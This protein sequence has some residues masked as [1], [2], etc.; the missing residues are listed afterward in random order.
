[1]HCLDCGWTQGDVSAEAG[2]QPVLCI[3]PAC[4]VAN[5][6][7]ERYCQRCNTLLPTAAGTMLQGRF[8]IESLLAEGGFGR[9]YR[10][11][12]IQTNQPVA[13]KDMISPDPAEFQ[14]RLTFFR[15]EAEILRELAGLEIVPRIYDFVEQGQSAHLIMEFIPGE[16]L[17]KILESRNNQPFPVDLVI[18]WGVKICRVLEVMHSRNPPII[19]RD[20]KPDNIMLLGDGRSIKLIDFGT[21]RDVSQ[22][23][24]GRNPGLTRVYTEGYAPPE[25]I[26]GKPEARS[27]LFALAATMYHLITGKAP[28]GFYAA[29]EVEAKL[30]DPN[31]AIPPEHRWLFELLRINLSESVNDRYYSAA[32]IRRDLEQR[33]LTTQVPCPKCQFVNRVRE[34]YCGRCAAP[35]TQA[36]P[37]CQ[38]CGKC[39]PLGSR[40]CIYCSHRLG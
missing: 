17:Q 21:A 26:V 31:G 13:I 24:K 38:Q 30:K 33:R 34:P 14:I 18:E 4:G 16:T 12:D 2:Q 11:K 5:S 3:N 15:R 40:F 29:R 37:P 9:V 8:Q 32:E 20:L 7:T 10:G 27:D 22:T 23:F 35:L 1:M 6:P 19:H 28:D 39:N 36:G 25:Q